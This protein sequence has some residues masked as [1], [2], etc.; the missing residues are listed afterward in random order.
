MSKI[1]LD[2]DGVIADLGEIVTRVANDLFAPQ[3]FFAED[4]FTHRVEEVFG[5]S[6]FDLTPF[7][8]KAFVDT[9][10]LLPFQNSIEAIHQLEE[11]GHEL[12]IA[13]ARRVPEPVQVWLERYGIGHIPVIW[14]H[15][16]M[17]MQQVDYLLDDY[18]SKL[19][20][21]ERYVTKQSFLM[22]QPWNYRCWN[23]RNKYRPVQ[24]WTEF[25]QEI[26]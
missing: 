19:L 17:P 5:L 18:V 9:T 21:L 10:T 25:L 4:F 2:F 15:H 12:V 11:A 16:S 26:E 24:T 20:R 6:E 22:E 13:T 23:V 7:V 8:E 14:L 3:V 1:A